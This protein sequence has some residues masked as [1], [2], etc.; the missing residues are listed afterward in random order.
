[1]DTNAL[2][3]EETVL[4]DALA[5][6]IQRMRTDKELERALGRRYA[7]AYAR[8]FFLREEGLRLGLYRFFTPT[9]LDQQI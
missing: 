8:W 5:E 7:K 4:R 1:M 9:K 3:K 6:L 2:L